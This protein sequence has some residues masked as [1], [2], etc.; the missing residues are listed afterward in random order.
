MWDR[1][2][3]IKISKM[4][5]ILL[6]L[7]LSLFLIFPQETSAAKADQY[8]KGEFTCETIV[9]GVLWTALSPKSNFVDVYLNWTPATTCPGV[10]GCDI[11]SLNSSVRYASVGSKDSTIGTGFIQIANRTQSPVPS[12]VASW[13]GI[14]TMARLNNTL[15]AGEVV[16]QELNVEMS[17]REIHLTLVLSMCQDL[18]TVF[19]T[20][21]FV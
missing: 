5:F 9:D 11:I 19:L 8:V 18:I 14:R 6:A 12:V 21:Q 1:R 17:R 20:T 4:M 10:K 13:T 7:A 15:L 3:A 16:G 2:G